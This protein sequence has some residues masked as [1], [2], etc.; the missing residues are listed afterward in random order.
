MRH[1]R[2][3]AAAFSI[4][5]LLGSSM[6]TYAQYDPQLAPGPPPLRQSMVNSV[7]M[8]WTWLLDVPLT[9]EEWY[10]LKNMVQ[11]NWPASAQTMLPDV[12]RWTQEA[13]AVPTMSPTE[14]AIRR[15]Q[16]F[17]ADFDDVVGETYDNHPV[18]RWATTVWQR[19][20]EPIAI[21]DGVGPLTRQDTDAYAEL[22]AFFFQE[23]DHRVPFDTD[24][25]SLD[26]FAT[27]AAAR[28]AQLP[29]EE[30]VEMT[31]APL[32]WREIRGMWPAATQTQRQNV[33]RTFEVL[34]PW[35]KD[36]F[37]PIFRFSTT[38][39]QP[40]PSPDGWFPFHLE[41]VKQGLWAQIAAGLPPGQ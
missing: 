9:Q 12:Q 26:K 13:A 32:L 33:T 20:N 1:L 17:H 7:G 38:Y 36:L 4:A 41:D 24:P 3:A 31:H 25:I 8:Y 29:G 14:S 34:I 2:L 15:A 22:S 5:S 18:Q 10:E 39:V 28:Y 27:V 37:A 21:A 30:Q 35:G 16:D 19:A 40:S 23:I 11:E 6:T